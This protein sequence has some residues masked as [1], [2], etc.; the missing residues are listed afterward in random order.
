ML[1]AI[2]QSVGWILDMITA[3]KAEWKAAETFIIKY[4][5]STL[6]ITQSCCQAS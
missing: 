3:I 6:R 5:D 1:F 4:Y 2:C